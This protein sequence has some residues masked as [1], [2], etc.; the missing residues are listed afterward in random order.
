MRLGRLAFPIIAVT[1][2]VLLA[3]ATTSWAA[4]GVQAP[5]VMEPSPALMALP[6]G[7]APDKSG[8]P[9]GG[10]VVFE[11]D[12]RAARETA[13]LAGGGTAGGGLSVESGS[14]AVTI[15]F[16]SPHTLVRVNSPIPV[17][18]TFSEPVSGFTVDDVIV[19]NGT[20]DGFTG[21]DG[22]AVYTF[23]VTPNAIGV[24]TADI[25]ADA[26][27]DGDRNGNTAAAQLWL[28]IP[29]DDDRDDGISKYE[30][31]S[32]V[33]DYFDGQLTKE[34][35]IGVIRLYFQAI[36]GADS[37]AL[38]LT[39][40]MLDGS[41][42]VPAAAFQWEQLNNGSPTVVLA[43]AD[44]ARASF[45]LPALSNNQ[46][47]IFR[48][49]VTYAGGHTS[50]DAVT[51][52]GRPTPG[53][54]AGAVSGHTASLNGSAEF[55]IRLR[56][57][58]SAEVV[59]PLSSSDESEGIPE[60]T[61][62]VFTPENWNR[63]QVVVVRGRNA[64]VQDGVQ[65]YQIVLG[66][67]QSPD[68][69]YDGLEIANVAMRG[70]A[71]GIAAPERIEPLIANILARIDPRVTY[72]GRNRLSFALTE[73]PVGMSID[74]SHGTISWTPQE[75]DEGRTFDVTVKVNDGALFSEA[76][77]QMTVIQPEPLATEIQENVLTVADPTTTL[78][79]LEITSPPDTPPITTETLEELQRTLE[80]V[81][82]ESVPEIPSWITPI[83][84][85]F[86]VTNS[87][88]N[89]AEIRFPIGELPAAVSVNLYAYTEALDVERQ[90]WSPVA[91][92]HSLEGAED[93]T[94]YV[95]S[96]GGL[97]G[98][99]F[100]GYHRTKPATP[101]EPVS[102]SD[103]QRTLAPSSPIPV[104]P[105]MTDTIE[106]TSQY[107]ILLPSR[108]ECI[109]TDY[110]DSKVVV[111]G[112]GGS[113]RWSGVTKEDFVKWA[114]MA[115]LGLK[116]LGLK[117]DNEVHIRVHPFIPYVQENVLGYVGSWPWENRK[118]LHINSDN[119]LLATNIQGTLVHEY[120]HHAQ[121]HEETQLP[122]LDLVLDSRSAAWLT[123]GTARWFEDELGETFDDLSTYQDKEGTGYRILERGLNSDGG[124]E[125]QR[126]YQRF[127]FF[128]LL[129]QS[130]PSLNLQFRNLMNADLDNDP[131]GIVSLSNLLDDAGCKFG[132][133]LGDARKG[134]MEAAL[135]Y[136]NY[137]T[138]WRDQI[139]LLDSNEPGFP[140]DFPTYWFQP[141]FA[142]PVN[143]CPDYIGALD[144]N[145]VSSI[146][147][148]GAYSFGVPFT[149]DLPEGKVAELVVDS[150]EEVIVSITSLD[151]APAFTGFIRENTIGPS[152][153]P[154]PH[155]WFSSSVETSYIFSRTTLPRI[156]VTLVNPSLSADVDV[157]VSFRIRDEVNVDLSV[158]PIITSHTDGAPVS[159]RV[160]T[161]RGSM[162]EEGRDA[163]KEVIVTANGIETRTALN[164]D[165]SFAADVVIGF[166]DNSIKAQGFDDQATPVT[167]ETGITIE[168]V[169][170][171]ST[172]PNALIPSRVV[173]VLRWD[174]DRT[175]IDLHSTDGDGGHIYFGR[176]TV[177][178]GNLDR[179][180]L[181]GFG[182]E[183]ISYRETDDNVYVNGT[184]DVDV[185]YFSGFRGGYPATNYTLDV[186]L[187]ESGVGDRRLRRFE[188]ITP[189]TRSD[190]R[191]ND[192]L[193]IFCGSERVCGLDHYDNTKLSP[194]G[195]STLLQRAS[196]AARS[197]RS[198][199]VQHGGPKPFPSAYE[200]CM[201]EL[202]TGL[203]KSG[204]VDWS[205]NP[206][207]TKQW[208]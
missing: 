78:D 29:Y 195:I 144:P 95:V 125:E 54:T 199:D 60:Q 92:E 131:T 117:Y 86:V 161:V 35:T 118:V 153:D 198:A 105:P 175:D 8:V 143:D 182:P 128:K 165:G 63:R 168:G 123:E 65:N 102:S 6:T 37:E 39:T 150:N 73:A 28:G 157:E 88:D 164:L 66:N 147:A 207:G 16:V 11:T 25:P 155:A 34:D 47:F 80:R 179:D 84:D 27:A 106:C 119:S 204:S 208:P 146:P 151:L 180:E 91:L 139:D 205:C 113:T 61:Q 169:A 196:S 197:A 166:G 26:A 79:G 69:F 194:T 181:Y 174:T 202:E 129:T 193:G 32:A 132:D 30:A 42:P 112:F 48:L 17:R 189:L 21:S 101:S 93:S 44:T 191:F 133:H 4:A 1:A 97:Q 121:G 98:M 56:S 50:Q 124:D 72:T 71:L 185:H 178:P 149:C 70:I 203:A 137:A 36:V 89:P 83:S 171:L 20:A 103:R 22:D 9:D 160:V 120:L 100:L 2:I 177:G 67:A 82:P 187:N 183:V 40:V 122:D 167:N 10:A 190:R 162:P 59:I 15:E 104:T 188:S 99:A 116:E 201:S 127:S 107:A 31:I 14:P 55:G 170:S 64:D 68:R 109:S 141:L 12:G 58:P 33:R 126:P 23:N 135:A 38:E 94:V 74:F 57:R 49:T 3:G 51:V 43:S 111:F 52:T 140:F 108:H 176:R 154:Q 46:D 200:Q 159:D 85:V 186:I 87:F 75:S 156:F 53:I 77:F 142:Q 138:Q 114:I 136:Y 192:I 81:P 206:D 172:R 7:P 5:G 148:A 134:T 145:R 45:T 41:A 173:F 158:G 110:P 184:F 19:G 115:Q 163:T 76:S 24:V 152:E 62:V 130:C 96:L 18:A 90:F 13:T